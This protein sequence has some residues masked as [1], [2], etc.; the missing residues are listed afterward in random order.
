MILIHLWRT[1]VL[2]IIRTSFINQAITKCPDSKVVMSGY[3]QGALVVRGTADSLSVETMSKVN[4]VVTF[5]DPRNKTAI[6]GAVGKTM[7]ICLPDDTVCQGG[8]INIAHLTY[9]TEASAAAQF[10]IQKAGV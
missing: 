4:S 5:G 6:T 1:E 10:V 2:I 7:I 8:F 9:A 3:S